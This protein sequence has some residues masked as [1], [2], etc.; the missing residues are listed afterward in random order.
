MGNES[1]NDPISPNRPR[2]TKKAR[3]HGKWPRPISIEESEHEDHSTL[4]ERRH[5]Q[6]AIAKGST[7][8]LLIDPSMLLEFIEEWMNDHHNP[9]DAL[10]I[11][12]SPLH[13]ISGIIADEKHKAKQAKKLKNLIHKR[14]K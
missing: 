12:A 14:K 8:P 7:I 11:P 2:N 10:D 4:V 1:S 13:V 6:S 3:D 9:L 5:R